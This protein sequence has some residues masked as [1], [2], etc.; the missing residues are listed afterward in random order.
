MNGTSSKPA[1]VTNSTRVPLRCRTALVATVVPTT[2]LCTVRARAS[3]S[4]ST[5]ASARA[6]SSGVEA[7]LP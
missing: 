7:C 6:G 1:V 5:A 4:F 3:T 2:M